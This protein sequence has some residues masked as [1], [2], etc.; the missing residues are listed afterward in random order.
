[1]GRPYPFDPEEITIEKKDM[2]VELCVRRMKQGTIVLN[3]DF[4]RN[5]IWNDEKKSQLIES[6]MLKIPIQ[7]FY[8]ATDKQENFIVVDGLQRLTAFRDF[9]LGRKGCAEGE[10]MRLRGLEY[11]KDYEGKT[12]GELPIKMQNRITETVLTFTIISPKTPKEVMFNIFKRIN[13][14][15]VQ[16][17]AQ[18]MRNALYTGRS[19][20]IL[21]RL[22]STDEFRLATAGSVKERR[23]TDCEVVL[24]CVAFI[25]RDFREYPTNGRMPQ[26]LEVTMQILNAHPHYES[27]DLAWSMEQGYLRA[28]MYRKMDDNE[29]ETLFRRGMAR[30]HKLF[31]R[32]CFRTSY[33]EQARKSINRS[34]VEMWG[35]LLAW[36]G[37]AEYDSL[38]SNK[39]AMM[40][41]YETLIDSPEFMDKISRHFDVYNNVQA[42]FSSVQ[43]LIT[44]YKR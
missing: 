40:R 10:S 2:L 43:N 12:F 30:S 9:I 24:R 16:L 13:T 23:M 19:T 18:E 38:L 34:L 29:I 37:E 7:M 36:L 17:N 11:L 35:S 26:F 28:G 33:G 20:K 44:K 27:E 4:Q 14:G 3:P 39:D 31:G 21:R 8:V 32:H 1:M 22:A 25:V 42:R 5:E 15:G 6:L 41:E